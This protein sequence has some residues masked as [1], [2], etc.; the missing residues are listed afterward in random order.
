MFWAIG[1]G[2]AFGRSATANN[3]FIG[4]GSF[5]LIDYNRFAF[6]SF[7]VSFE[8]LNVHL[9]FCSGPFLPLQLIL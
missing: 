9:L 2:F 5:F 1:F 6:W 4:T 8:K 3:P 7:E